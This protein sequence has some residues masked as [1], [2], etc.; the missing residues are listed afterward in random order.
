MKEL[1]K[2]IIEIIL[3]NRFQ[4][5]LRYYYLK[6]FNKLDAEMIY[7][8]KLLT[9]NRRFLDIG[10]NVGIYSF[11]FR[12][13]FK[14]IDSFEPISEIT[15]RLKSLQAPHIHIHNIALSN[16]RGHIDFYIPVIN[17]VTTPARASIE[18]RDSQNI[19]RIVKIR[20]VDSYDFDD[21]DLIKIDVEG[22]EE[23]VIKGAQN[24]IKKTL[25]IILVEIEQRHINKNICEIY[26]EILDMNYDGFFLDNGKLVSIN[27]FSYEVHQKP[28]LENTMSKE[29][30]NNFIFIPKKKMMPVS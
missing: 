14:N 27:N 3:P 22:H 13:C 28:F 16:R 6:V 12:S 23:S 21:I 30:I 1:L 5:H 25:P 11:Y 9:N 17:G 4:L 7:I 8:S 19:K 26:K 29:Y 15:Y 18:T 20:T 10:A 2:R 24:S